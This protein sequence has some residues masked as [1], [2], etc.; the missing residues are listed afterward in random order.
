MRN[1]VREKEKFY[2]Q[3]KEKY[4]KKN[5]SKTQVFHFDWT[6]KTNNIP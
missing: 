5:E 4:Y 3:N 6:P 2:T 1:Y